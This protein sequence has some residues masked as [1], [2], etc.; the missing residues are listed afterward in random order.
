MKIEIDIKSE[1]LTSAFFSSTELKQTLIIYGCVELLHAAQQPIKYPSNQEILTFMQN[2]FDEKRISISEMIEGKYLIIYKLDRKIFIFC[3][4]HS[5]QRIYYT[6]N[7]SRL[8]ISDNLLSD[9]SNFQISQQNAIQFL[10]FRFVSGRQT[11]FENIF[12]IMPCDCLVLDLEN[13]TLDIKQHFIFPKRD[14][15]VES[16][17]QAGELMHTL[18]RNALQ[19]RIDK[20]P[21]ETL[22]LPT[23][24]GMDSRYI[25][26]T[27]LELVDSK[28]ILALTFGTKGTYDFEIGALVAKTAGVRHVGFPLTYEDYILD[29]ELINNCLDTDGQINFITELPLKICKRY[30]EYGKFVLSG[31]LGDT[32]MGAK[33]SSQVFNNHTDIILKDSLVKEKSVI[34]KFISDATIESSFYYSANDNSCLTPFEDWFFTNHFCKYTNFCVFKNR[35]NLSY[36]T[37]FVDYQFFDFMINLPFEMRNSRNL[38]FQTICHR[39]PKLASVPFKSYCGAPLNSSKFERYITKQW[40]RVNVRVL[41]SDKNVNY[42]PFLKYTD[43]IVKIKSLQRNMKGILPVELHNLIFQN[44]KYSLLLFNLKCLEILKFN[45]SVKILTD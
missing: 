30:E 1:S 12:Q 18:F 35:Q 17:T 9:F 5:I 23:S 38:Y 31:Y 24:G 21:N 10:F 34:Q 20:H 6:F 29:I 27:A 36:M 26:A 3:D 44:S 39:F 19:T 2:N 25:L 32:V 14:V 7:N 43:K 15:K 45:F 13:H 42:I 11:L 16:F 37:P 22:L 4:K 28:R 41:K 8:T 33:T 40:N